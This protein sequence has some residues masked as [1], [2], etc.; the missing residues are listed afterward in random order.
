MV[1]T[2]RA[3]HKKFT[4][5]FPKLWT[6]KFHVLRSKTNS[7]EW[8][9]GLSECGLPRLPSG[10]QAS[11]FINNRSYLDSA[12]SLFRPRRFASRDAAGFF[13]SFC[14]DAI[15]QPK[16][17]VA[18]KPSRQIVTVPIPEFLKNRPSQDHACGFLAR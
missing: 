6:R 13:Y 5:I 9:Q 17:T 3:P 2:Q 12:S 7:G 18:V 16:W 11:S 10:G 15:S 1:Q 8:P 4:K 14:K